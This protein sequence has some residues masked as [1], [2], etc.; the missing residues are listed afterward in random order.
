MPSCDTVFGGYVRLSEILIVVFFQ[1]ESDL[2]KWAYECHFPD[3][4]TYYS[5]LG[6]TTE[7]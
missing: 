1:V 5:D 7:M 2:A 6:D 4:Q 3:D